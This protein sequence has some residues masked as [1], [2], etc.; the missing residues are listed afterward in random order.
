MPVCDRHFGIIS[1]EEEGRWSARRGCQAKDD[2]RTRCDCR[3]QQVFRNTH[4]GNRQ[5]WGRRHKRRSGNEAGLAPAMIREGIMSVA[6]AVF[7][8]KEGNRPVWQ[9]VGCV[10]CDGDSWVE[11]WRLVR[12][13]DENQ[14]QH[15]DNARPNA[16]ISRWSLQIVPP[17]KGSSSG[18]RTKTQ[19]GAAFCPMRTTCRLSQRCWTW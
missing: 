3:R 12:E 2:G 11:L 16:D 7:V 10:F 6:T 15:A 18:K 4:G 19:C 17:D 8:A 5:R 9:R 14:R 1:G 13:T